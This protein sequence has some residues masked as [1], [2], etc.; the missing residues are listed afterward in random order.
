MLACTCAHIQT[1]TY[2][3]RN[4]VVLKTSQLLLWTMPQEESKNMHT[5]VFQTLCPFIYSLL[6]FSKMDSSV[7]MSHV[8][9]HETQE[10]HTHS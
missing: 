8:Q 4:S 5:L 7:F 6:W 1:Y 3:E 10:D 2:T 9:K